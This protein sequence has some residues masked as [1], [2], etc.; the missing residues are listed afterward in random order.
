MPPTN[1]VEHPVADVVGPQHRGAAVR[2]PHETR[3]PASVRRVAAVG[4]V[5]QARCSLSRQGQGRLQ[6]RR[7]G[8][9]SAVGILSSM[10]VFR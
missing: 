9:A 1:G 10:T 2:N 3:R 5:M 8:G 6:T 4:P 7:C